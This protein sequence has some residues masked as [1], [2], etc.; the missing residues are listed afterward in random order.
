MA[1]FDNLK[2]KAEDVVD[3]ATDKTKEGIETGKLNRNINAEEKAIQAAYIELGKNYFEREKDNI[4]A[5]DREIIN[6]IKVSMASIEEM[7][8]QIARIKA[9][10]DVV[11]E[12]EASQEEAIY[13]PQCNRVIEKTDKFCPACGKALSEESL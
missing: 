8:D 6:K 1:F 12:A 7:R 4:D 5:F 2:K 11:G 13:C 9:K 3:K 10:E